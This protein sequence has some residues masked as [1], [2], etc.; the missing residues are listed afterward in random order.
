MDEVTI[1]RYVRDW[2]RA[3]IPELNAG[4]DYV[5]AMKDQ[6]P[7]VQVNLTDTRAVYGG[8]ERFP[9]G[10]LIENANLLIYEMDVSFMVESGDGAPLSA[11]EQQDKLK[12]WAKTLRLAIHDD[13]QLPYTDP[14]DVDHRLPPLGASPLVAF[15]FGLPF[16]QYDDGT[17]GRQMSMALAIAEL[18]QGDDF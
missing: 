16:V 10:E 11:Q 8:D 2:C 17:R 15:D 4:Y 5:T 13:A 12:E 6:L 1:P 9:Y 7:D 18:I 14:G 3:T